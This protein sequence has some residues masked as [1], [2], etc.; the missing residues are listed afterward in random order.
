MFKK[1][2]NLGLNLF[3]ITCVAPDSF[4][5]CLNKYCSSKM[6]PSKLECYNVDTLNIT[7][8]DG[9]K[10]CFR[11]IQLLALKFANLTNLTDIGIVN[12][13]TEL[14]YL[15]LSNINGF[16]SY[17]LKSMLSVKEVRILINLYKSPF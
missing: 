6:K 17:L 5:T 10:P 4:E 11:K 12:D 13:F 2:L 1:L 8:S 16:D 14:Y 7:Q 9:L 3:L 15:Q